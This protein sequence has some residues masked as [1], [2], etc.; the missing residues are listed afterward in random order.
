MGV[1]TTSCKCLKT[2][3]DFNEEVDLAKGDYLRTKTG[4]IQNK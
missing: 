4:N 1:Q 3:K 2:C